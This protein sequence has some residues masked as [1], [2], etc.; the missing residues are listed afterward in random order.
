MKIQPSKKPASCG[1]ASA[2]PGPIPQQNAMW[3]TSLPPPA[4]C[5]VITAPLERPILAEILHG[6]KLAEQSLD[7]C[8]AQLP[9]AIPGSSEV[10][11]KLPRSCR[12]NVEQWTWE[13]R[14]GPTSTQL[15]NYGSSSGQIW[16]NLDQLLP[17]VANLGQILVVA[18]RIW[19]NLCQSWLNLG[20]FRPEPT[21]IRPNLAKFGKGWPKLGQTVTPNGQCW[22][23]LGRFSVPKATV[24]QLWGN[25]LATSAPTGIVGGNYA[26]HASGNRAVT[27]GGPIYLCQTRPLGGRRHHNSFF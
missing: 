25:F 18:G 11:P 24:R 5:F 22:P 14:I 23:K 2:S 27:F 15:G 20:K 12:T 8:H 7:T 4:T 1:P 3:N 26:R 10:A 6:P 16:P 17:N 9:P 13:P 19:P 21:E